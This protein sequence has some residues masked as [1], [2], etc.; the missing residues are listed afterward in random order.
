[1]KARYVENS[2][3]FLR[4]FALEPK[5]V[6][7]FSETKL[8]RL[9]DVIALLPSAD[10]L[11]KAA[12]L[13][14]DFSRL[15]NAY[16]NF[17]AILCAWLHGS[18]SSS[19][20]LK[21]RIHPPSDHGVEAW[22]RSIGLHDV[23]EGHRPAQAASNNSMAL[24]DIS[25]G[26]KN[27]PDRISVKIMDLI[28]RTG[29]VLSE[30]AHRS[31]YTAIAEILENVVR[32]SASNS[33]AFV[34][35]QAHPKQHKFSFCIADAGV[36]I[37]DSFARGP[38]KVPAE[39]IA[40][41]DDPLELAIEPF[42]SS[43]YGMGHSGWGLFYASELCR[44]A[45][46][47]FCLTSGDESLFIYNGNQHIER[48]PYWQGTIAY[49]LLSTLSRI[50]G[51]RVWAKLPTAEE[52]SDFVANFSNTA[53]G[54]YALHVLGDG[55]RR[56]FTRDSAKKDLDKLLTS[57]VLERGVVVSVE[58][59]LVATPSYVDEFFCGLLRYLGMDRFK[60]LVLI[61]GATP[62]LTM[63]IEM[64]LQNEVR[65]LNS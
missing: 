64:V 65:R 27:A 9:R 34:C 55:T 36:G 26:D 32:H 31:T 25:P 50:D 19:R 62:Y 47:T 20:E 18:A 63:I 38:Y 40:A 43:K 12:L 37:R 51:S 52:E 59:V 29:I 7:G 33:P 39:R 13:V 1:M 57:G 35:A 30:D 58:E 54:E 6:V 17:A 60:K 42:I 2:A 44:E 4:V 24:V 14:L 41:G 21:V 49:V 16:P 48:H 8:E 22:L 56:L 5:I 28:D 23:I 45:H 15:N 53:P 11:Q 61:K 3:G 46:G 10:E